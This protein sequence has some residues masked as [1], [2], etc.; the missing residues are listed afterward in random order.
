MFL[1]VP[2][3]SNTDT[4]GTDGSISRPRFSGIDF[5]FIVMNDIKKGTLETR[6]LYCD[7]LIFLS[8]R[9]SI[10]YIPLII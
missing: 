2:V 6:I 9:N 5:E 1:A 4:C 3:V 7:K 8:F 10:T